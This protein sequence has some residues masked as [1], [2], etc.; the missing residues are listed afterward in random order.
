MLAEVTNKVMSAAPTASACSPAAP[1]TATTEYPVVAEIDETT[2]PFRRLALMV[3]TTPEGGVGKGG[4]LAW[5]G[6]SSDMKRF[7]AI[8]TGAGNNAVVMGRKTWLSIPPKFRPLPGRLNVV[9]SRSTDVREA[10]DIPDS[11]KVAASFQ[12]VEAIVAGV[13]TCFIIGGACVYNEA[14]QSA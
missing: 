6:L 1:A 4:Q 5:K 9:L 2:H 10:C 11:V 7:K 3:A 8:T 12:D 14:I 13:D